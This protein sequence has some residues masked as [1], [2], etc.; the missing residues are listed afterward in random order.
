MKTRTIFLILTILGITSLADAQD[1]IHTTAKLP[2]D[3]IIWPLVETNTPIAVECSFT[4]ETTFHCVTQGNWEVSEKL[5]VYDVTNVIRGAYPYK[6]LIF[7]CKHQWPTKESG[8]MMKALVWSFKKGT[9]TFYL[10][11]DEECRT[12][13]YFN[14]MAYSK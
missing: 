7:V 8:I 2:Q 4:S 12:K 11:K 9:K 13:D 3:S 6:Q 1:K 5:I 10:K 14:I